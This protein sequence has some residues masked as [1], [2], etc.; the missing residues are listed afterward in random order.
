MRA[1]MVTMAALLWVS[2]SWAYEPRAVETMPVAPS[3]KVC[4]TDADCV[5]VDIHCGDCCN[6]DAIALAKQSI[7]ASEKQKF[8]HAYP[9]AC[10]CSLPAEMIAKPMCVHEQCIVRI[11]KEKP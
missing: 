7:F 9:T 3:W 1:V 11:E 4:H 5:M 2:S 6:Y 10:D 8:C